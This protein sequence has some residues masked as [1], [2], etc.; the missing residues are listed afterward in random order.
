VNCGLHING[1]LNFIVY[2][3]K[4]M[5]DGN[6]VEFSLREIE[7]ATE[8]F[9]SAR[10][11][12][13]PAAFGIKN[14]SSDALHLE[15]GNI[16]AE[17]DFRILFECSL[18][19]TLK[20]RN[21]LRFVIPRATESDSAALNVQI[22]VAQLGEIAS[23]G[24]ENQDAT[25]EKLSP[26]HGQLHLDV[27]PKERTGSLEISIQ[28]VTPVESAAI[29]A[30]M[31]GQTYTGVAAVADIPSKEDLKCELYLV[32]DCS[33]SM[34]GQSISVA[35]ATLNF[36]LRSLP[37]ECLFNVIRFG[38]GFE[39]MFPTSVP[40]TIESQ[41]QAI[42][43]IGVMQ[44]N[45]G[46]TDL[47][48][49][50]SY[51]LDLA[52]VPG[53]SR[54]IF[55][56]TDGHVQGESQIIALATQHRR[57]HRIFSVGIGGSV[58]R[59]FIEDLA[60]CTG[61][62]S[63]FVP[64][65]GDEALVATMSQ[66]KSALCPALVNCQLHISDIETF[67]VSPF[68]IPTLFNGVLYHVYVRTERIGEDAGIL[69]AGQ[70]G[71]RQ[72]DVASVVYPASPGIRL[73]KFFAYFNIRDLEERISL[74]PEPEIPALKGRVVR[75]SMQAAIVSQFTALCGFADAPGSPQRQAARPA[76]QVAHPSPPQVPSQRVLKQEMTRRQ[77]REQVA[78]DQRAQG[79][80]MVQQQAM[81]WGGQATG[82][83]RQRQQQMAP[84]PQFCP[85]QQMASRSLQSAQ[86]SPVQAQVM[87]QRQVQQCVPKQ[88]RRAP[89][90]QRVSPDSGDEPE[91]G[92]IQGVISKQQFHGY[93]DLQLVGFE[94]VP[95]D[96]FP[97]IIAI[98]DESERKRAQQT[99]FA[100]ATLEKSGGDRKV[101]WSLIREKAIEWL[102][103]QVPSINWDGIIAQVQSFIP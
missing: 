71:E 54:Q 81:H 50:L 19:A 23:V 16:P 42:Q 90:Q 92:G 20:D 73:D 65:G 22:A 69:I 24:I 100:L 88:S 68:P 93:W 21:Q 35:R 12:G 49:P 77:H 52:T 40:F 58:D 44:A 80:Q 86:F 17:S 5:I 38:S 11:Q 102:E 47:Y 32:I 83:G 66:L 34:S 62:E 2:N 18:C 87:G 101:L 43:G 85:S 48:S 94:A 97:E 45:L 56:L 67:E 14:E 37:K 28:L 78:W 39:T 29:T 70:A 89:P 46:G 63:A 9:Q 84:S 4:A 79:V 8:A 13:H 53:Y 82:M 10:T 98:D 57:N 26:T 25:F 74:A 95:W 55:V 91:L 36:F 33:G 61:G 3:V 7:E 27:P 72:V 76:A 60:A 103:S 6:D 31:D 30:S 99:L 75:L 41:R 15:I 59:T 96:Q 1:G 51:I 64:S